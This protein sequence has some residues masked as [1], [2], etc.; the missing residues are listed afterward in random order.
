MYVSRSRPDPGTVGALLITYLGTGPRDLT[1]LPF[2]L[3]CER[4]DL[5]KFIRDL[6]V[7]WVDQS[8]SFSEWVTPYLTVGALW[9]DKSPL[10]S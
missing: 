4:L 9:G 3:I 5:W 8:L 2:F 10:N 7:D 1:A 6:K